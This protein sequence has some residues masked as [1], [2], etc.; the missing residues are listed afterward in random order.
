MPP[1]TQP[2]AAVFGGTRIGNREQFMPHTHLE[3]FLQTLTR[4]RVTKI[5]TAQAYG[6]SEATLGT[7]QAG[8]R[9]VIDTKWSPPSWTEPNI[10][11]ATSERIIRSAEE[12]I[13]KLAVN[14]VDIF[15]LHRPDPMTPISETLAA[16]NAIHKR[17][18]FRRFGLSGFPAT[19]IEAVYNHCADHSYPLP[20][21]Y[22]GSYN[23]LNR[24]K[25]TAL[26]L[27]LRRLR[28][29]FYAYGTSAG[30]FLCKTAAQA[31]EMGDSDAYVS[32]TCRPYL[33]NANFVEILAQWNTIAEIEGVSPAELT[34]RWVAYHSA[35]R[36]DHGDAFIIG[37][38]TPEQLDE[39]LSGIEKGLLSDD[40]CASI[41][42][43]WEQAKEV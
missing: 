28:I 1:F 14:Q 26:L 41:Q 37:A 27:T 4:H 9:F 40:A 38:S 16:V 34:Y 21:V 33:R 8:S 6:S 35:L 7:I 11:W 10:P 15:Y 20:V 29:S 23:P 22:Q 42:E 30:G 3:A 18:V 32:A 17:G 2:V 25:E 36:S 12:S 5:D 43:I 13:N 31:R 19:E 24:H 39:T